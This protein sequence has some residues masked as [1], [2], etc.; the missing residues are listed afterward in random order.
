MNKELL[1]GRHVFM[2]AV[3]R[4]KNSISVEHEHPLHQIKFMYAGSVIHM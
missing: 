1:N 3:P 2:L 4:T